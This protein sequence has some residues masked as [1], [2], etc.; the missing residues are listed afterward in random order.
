MSASL[1]IRHSGDVAVVDISG[2]ITLGE[3]SG[4]L[5]ENLRGLMAEGHTKI[6]LNMSG[7]TFIDSSGIGELVSG[8]VSVAH[9]HGRVK[10]CCLG[11]RVR[12]LLQVTRL[13]NVLDVYEWEDDALRS[14]V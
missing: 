3:S 1:T 2:R 4:A 8:Y 7:V 9:N 5:R 13:Y 10:L 6:L 11:K 12:D 14:F